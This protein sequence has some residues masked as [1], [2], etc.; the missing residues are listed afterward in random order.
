MD[1]MFVS[2]EN[3]YVE[4]LSPQVIVLGGGIFGKELGPEDGAPKVKLVPL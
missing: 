3:S 2:S 1:F 4:T